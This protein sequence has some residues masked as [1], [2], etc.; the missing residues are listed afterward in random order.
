MKIILS[1]KGF[2]S[3]TGKVPSPILPSGQLCSLPIPDTYPAQQITLRS[4][5]EIRAG[6]VS[7]GQLVDDLTRGRI[8]PALPTH[9]DPDLNAASV[10]R[11]PGWRP[12]FGQSGAAETHLRRQGV[13]PGD[14]FLFYGWFRQVELANGRFRYFPHAPDWHVLFGWLQIE[15]RIPLTAAV[16]IPPWTADHPHCQRCQIRNPDALYIARET[17]DLS[18]VDQPGGGIFPCFHEGLRLTDPHSQHRSLWRL[19][20]WF[21]P[22]NRPSHLSY[23]GRPKSWRRQDGFVQL[24]TVGRGQEFVLDCD[25]Y[26]EAADWLQTLF[27]CDLPL[28]DKA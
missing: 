25:H 16:D 1:R 22:E 13:G 11:L 21:H 8:T 28:I 18:G 6:D 2:D 19:P 14:L 27:T 3:A 20:V 26:P 9:L 7:V 10:P 5:Q 4:Y 23:H 12:V 24:Q 15:R 17:L